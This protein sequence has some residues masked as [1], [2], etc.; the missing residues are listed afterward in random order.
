MQSIE[1]EFIVELT[2][3][4]IKVSDVSDK[5]VEWY[6]TN[7]VGIEETYGIKITEVSYVE[8]DIFKIKYSMTED[9]DEDIDMLNSMLVDVDDDG[10]YPIKIGKKKYLVSGTLIES[11]VKIN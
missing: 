9:S 5:L 2:N 1:F 4:S 7:C 8:R 11:S 3:N 10:N 6:K